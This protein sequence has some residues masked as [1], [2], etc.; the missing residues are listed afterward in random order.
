V[1]GIED[2]G[3]ML[4][5]QSGAVLRFL[6]AHFLHSTGNFSAF[7]E[8]SGVLFS[9]DIGAAI[10]PPG[11]ET[12]FIDDFDAVIPFI[13]AFHKRYMASNKVTAKWAKAAAALS[14]KLMAAQ[15]GGVY[16]GAAVGRFIEWFSKL[17]CGM[18]Q[19]DSIYKQ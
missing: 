7:D 10:F 12:L 13:E 3:P 8:R 17:E 16:R 6:P 11:K 15:H 18:D 9:G 1:L 4:K 19:L 5:F 14:P 2:T